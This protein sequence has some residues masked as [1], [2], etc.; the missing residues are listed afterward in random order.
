MAQG[1]VLSQSGVGE[2][3]VPELDDA[4]G[5]VARGGPEL[6][7]AATT[8]STNAA[9][10]VARSPSGAAATLTRGVSGTT[11]PVSPDH[12]LA[13]AGD[14]E[15]PKRTTLRRRTMPSTSAALNEFLRISGK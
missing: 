14:S 6:D 3:C 5:G 13:R 4:A 11:A 9:G 10:G 8:G 7:D 12:V 15:V 1:A 2:S